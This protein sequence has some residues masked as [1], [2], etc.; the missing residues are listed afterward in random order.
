MPNVGFKLN[1]TDMQR[2]IVF[3]LC[4]FILI[5]NKFALGQKSGS[6]GEFNPAGGDKTFTN[7]F[8][9]ADNV[10]PVEVLP[11]NGALEAESLI[12]TGVPR[13]IKVGYYQFKLLKNPVTEFLII[14]IPRPSNSPVFVNIYNLIG[15]MIFQSKEQQLPS[16]N[17]TVQVDI[18]SIPP[19][20]YIYTI[21]TDKDAGS[22]K[23]IKR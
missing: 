1:R 22:G 5:P 23:F 14:S 17:P 20:T 21:R 12:T 2:I 7:T 9:I 15:E 18:S 3:I 4:L 16:S 13:D 11:D 8:I 6:R 10:P 19:G